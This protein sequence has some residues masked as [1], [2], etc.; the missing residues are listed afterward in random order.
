MTDM[1][2]LKK[3]IKAE[4]SEEFH[5]I[6][7]DIF[8][9]LERFTDEELAQW[10]QYLIEGNWKEAYKIKIAKMNT[11]ELLDEFDRLN[12]HFRTMNLNNQQR[13]VFWRNVGRNF[14]YAL[15]SF[16]LSCLNERE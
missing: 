10:I 14:L 8:I 1:D 9:G 3:K 6:I 16:G 5:S 4:A 2:K 13:V 12:E 7:D 11:D 15:I